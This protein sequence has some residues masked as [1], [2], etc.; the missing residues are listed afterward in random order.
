VQRVKGSFRNYFHS[1]CFLRFVFE[2]IEYLFSVFSVTKNR[3][4][5]SNGI[6]SGL[7]FGLERASGHAGQG[8][9]RANLQKSLEI[10]LNEQPVLSFDPSNRGSKLICKKLDEYCPGKFLALGIF[11]PVILFPFSQHLVKA[12]R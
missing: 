7:V 2:L 5:V 8:R 4:G 6:V 3:T 10:K 9:S 12:R 1:S 11:S